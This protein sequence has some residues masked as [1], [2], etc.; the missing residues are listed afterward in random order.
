MRTTR[1]RE[2]GQIIVLFALSLVVLL[3]LGALLYGGAQTLVQ[4]RQLQNAGDAAALAAANVM[5]ASSSLCTSARI[6]PTATNGANDIYLAAKN[7]VKTNLSWSD[8]QVA[9]RMTVA[10]ATDSSYA[11]SAVSVDLTGTAAGYFGGG[12]HTV[13]TSSTAINGQVGKGDF[14]VAL[15]DPSNPSWRANRNGCPSFLINGGITASFE[16]SIMVDSLCSLADSSNGAVKALNAAF[17]MVMVNGSAVRVAGE[18]NANT[19]GKITPAP[20]EHYRPLLSDPLAGL[21]RPC[22]AVDAATSCLG[23][24]TSLPTV[25]MSGT[26]TGICKDQDPCIITPGTYTDGIHA[27]GGSNAP[28]TVLMRPGVYYIRGGGMSL[29]S[30]SARI[31]AIPAGS[32]TTGYLDATA[33][34]DFAI[35]KTQL[36][37]S[38]MFMSKCPQPSP[39]N[40][41]PSTCGVMIY[42]APASTSSNWNTN[43]DKINVGAQGVFQVR[44]YVPANDTIVSNR[45]LFT[46]YKN[47]VIW[48]AR[49][50]AP[51]G[52]GQTQ[53]QLAMAGGGCITLSGTLYASGGQVD[54]GGGSCGSGGGDNDLTL[55]FI[56]WDLTLSGNNNFYFAYQKEYFTIPTAYG[57]VK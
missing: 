34:A 20:T 51:T 28:S 11:S 43:Q 36:Q 49:T 16:G 29:K 15:L 4:R 3:A 53:P 23:G 6:S 27:G 55:Q 42:N 35:S 39:S 18:V 57:L 17:Q 14:S 31:F 2:N 24:N 12:S 41:T 19:V 7:S 8:A 13:S 25:N 33:I 46:S 30:G 56:C 21:I 44:A 5:Q 38:Q 32:A 10:C 22:N 40:P 45:S 37:A 9:S 48:Q 50:P 1:R 47:L 54:F 26:G 52:A